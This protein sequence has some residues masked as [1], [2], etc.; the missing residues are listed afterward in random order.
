MN[1]L[2]TIRPFK[3]LCVSIGNLPTSYFESMSYYECLTFLVKFLENQVIPVVNNNSEVVKELQDYVEHYFDNLDVQDEINTKLDE[4]AESGELE[5]IIMD[6]INSNATWNFDSVADM[7]LASGLID[8][9]Y[10]KTLGYYDVN[11]GGGACYKVRTK[12]NADTPN[13]MTLIAIGDDLVADLIENG[14]INILQLGAKGDNDTENGDI[15]KFACN[16]FN[17]VYVP[18]GEYKISQNCIINNNCL[19]YGDGKTSKLHFYGSAENLGGNTNYTVS[20]K[21]LQLINN[22][23]IAY[24]LNRT[25]IKNVKIEDCNINATGYGVLVNL[26]T[27]NGENIHIL[28][29][30][31]SSNDDG[32]EINTTSTSEDKFKNVFVIGNKISIPGGSGD[33]S[34]FGIGVA[35]GKNITIT[36]NIIDNSRL[37]ALHIEGSSK[38]VIISNN[39]ATNCQLHGIKVF[40]VYGNPERFTVT[41]NQL[42]GNGNNTG[43]YLVYNPNG[44]SREIYDLS[45]NSISNFEIG[46]NDSGNIDGCQ[47]I[48]C[49]KAVG[50]EAGGHFKGNLTLVNTPVIANFTNDR[51]TLFDSI[52]TKDYIDPATIMTSTNSGKSVMI[53]N[54]DYKLQIDVG[55]EN[56]TV[57]NLLKLPTYLNAIMK[58]KI[59]TPTVNKGEAIVKISYDSTNGLQKEVLYE[60]NTGSF[61]STSN[62]L[63]DDDMLTLNPYNPTQVSGFQIAEVSINGEILYT[64]EF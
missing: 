3:N 64:G 48:S 36:N 29:N 43:I 15:F 22:Q 9:S 38:K 55:S 19:I 46:I 30:E 24:H 25:G 62:I 56:T 17:K 44:D 58:V 2:K 14:N 21:D 57:M 45:N 31:I 28:N 33:G 23:G 10:T 32:V 49:E 26:N 51:Y 18:T 41:N 37:E 63:I 40:N 60:N 47:I 59:V 27:D 8:G 11:D 54:F 34:G 4:M 7:K 42:S 16:N 1:N 6:F 61:A 13:D 35:D 39:I 12:T 53:K 5:A 20:I 50:N 52:T